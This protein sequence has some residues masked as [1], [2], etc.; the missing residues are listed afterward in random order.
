MVTSLYG[1]PQTFSKKCKPKEFQKL[2]KN[3][4]FNPMMEGLVQVFASLK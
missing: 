2:A 4:F 3:M 1:T